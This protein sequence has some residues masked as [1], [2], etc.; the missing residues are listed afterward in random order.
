MSSLSRKTLPEGLSFEALFR[1]DPEREYF[2][3]AIEH[4]FHRDE[5]GFDACNAWWL[6]ELS[7]LCYVRDGELV[8]EILGKAG[9]SDVVILDREG[10]LC[11]VADDLVAFRGTTDMRDVLRDIDALFTPEGSGRVHRGFKKA[12]EPLW[13]ELSAHFGNR[14]A[15]FTGH[16]MGAAL[17]TLAGNRYA[18]TRAVYTYGSPR[19]GDSAY[20]SGTAAP[21]YRVVNNND[22]VTRMPPPASFRH[23]GTLHYLDSAGEMRE[24]PRLADR[25]RSQVAGHG[26]RLVESVRRW[27]AGEFDAIPY[28]S[29]VDHSPQHYMVHMWNHYVSKTAGPEGGIRKP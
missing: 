15:W 29:L 9:I 20:A 21:V 10:A 26:I 2:L 6:A 12:L 18:N 14:P 8:H 16:S 24:D 3:N 7:M 28:D 13:E 11:I 25:L 5:S 4:P 22:F 17:A 23:V 1:P 27:L 19:V